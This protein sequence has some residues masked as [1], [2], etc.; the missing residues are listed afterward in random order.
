MLEDIGKIERVKR[1]IGKG[2]KLVGFIYNHSL[3]L[4]TMRRFTNKTE[5]VRHGVTRFAT[6]FLTLQRLHKQRKNLR[7]MFISE[8]WENSKASKDPKGKVARRTVLMPAFWNDVFFSLKVMGPLV[9]VLRLVD[10]EKKLAM[11]YIYEA[12]DRAKEA[13]QKSFGGDEQKYKDIFA[14]IDTRWECQLHHLLHAAGHYLNPEFFYG[15]DSIG[16]D[17]EVMVGLFKCIE[18]LSAN[19]AEND[20]ITMQLESYRTAEGLFGIKS[21]IRQM[22]LLAPTQWW[23]LYG[24]Q[25]PNLRDFAIKVLSLTCSSSGCER[26]WSTFEHIHSKKRSRLEHQKLQDLVFIKYNQ[27]LKHRYDSHDV[28]D[29]IILKD[30]D[31]SNEWLVGEVGEDNAEDENIFYDDTLTLGVVADA[32]GIGE[33]LTYTRLQTRGTRM[34]NQVV[35]SVLSE[36]EEEQIYKLSSSEDGIEGEDLV[37]FFGCKLVHFF[38]CKFVHFFGYKFVQFFG[39]KFVNF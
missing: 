18:R 37:H 16:N 22:T 26:N 20:T 3:A 8:D 34:V 7:N 14:I 30:I 6:T 25:T 21:A 9:R 19:E 15:N 23:K 17:R 11:G 39:Y 35:P 38:G 5:L 2:I 36:D 29:L 13:I 27:A 24:S 12:M 31:D 33:P 4:N 32:S 1:A 10:N 28:I